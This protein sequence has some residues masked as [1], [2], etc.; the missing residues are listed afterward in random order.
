MV[1]SDAQKKLEVLRAEKIIGASLE[2]QLDIKASGEVFKALN[3]LNKSHAKC[4]LREFFIVSNVT[5][6]EGELSVTAT[7]AP[8]E[9]CVRCWTYSESIST[10][11]ATAGICPKCVEALT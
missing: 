5:L 3:D 11:A 2:A 8:G 10:S 9:K 7:K 4:N 1:R 6:S